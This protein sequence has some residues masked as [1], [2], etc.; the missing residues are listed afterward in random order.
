MIQLANLNE[1]GSGSLSE[2]VLKMIKD[3]FKANKK[4]LFKTYY[5]RPLK[6]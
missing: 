5:I 1:S 6:T 4:T 2:N 3:K